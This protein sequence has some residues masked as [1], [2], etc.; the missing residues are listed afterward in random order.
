[1]LQ[2]CEQNLIRSPC[3]IARKN[4]IIPLLPRL[5]KINLEMALKFLIPERKQKINNW[6]SKFVQKKV[7]VKIRLG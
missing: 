6:L 5:V 2:K 7:K 3:C 4:L 1:M